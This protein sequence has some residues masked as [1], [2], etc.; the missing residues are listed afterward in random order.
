MDFW[1]YFYT[2]VFRIYLTRGFSKVLDVVTT[3]F[4]F[5]LAHFKIPSGF[6]TRVTGGDLWCSLVLGFLEATLFDCEVARWMNIVQSMYQPLFTLEIN[7][8][9]DIT[10]DMREFNVQ[11]LHL[12]IDTLEYVS[13]GISSSTTTW[14]WPTHLKLK[15]RCDWLILFW[16]GLKGILEMT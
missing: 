2:F 7:T 11:D 3:N 1:S 8:S 9:H 16:L 15:G 10:I 5:P 12:L 4:F 14:T 13:V 6:E